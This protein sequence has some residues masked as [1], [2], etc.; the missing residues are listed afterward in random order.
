MKS[1]MINHNFTKCQ[2]KG[3]LK[4]LTEQLG[5]MERENEDKNEIRNKM[6]DISC[7]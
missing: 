1:Q 3:I 7:R 6:L 2:L 5:K 4:A